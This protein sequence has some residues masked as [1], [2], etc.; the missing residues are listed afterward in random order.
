MDGCWAREGVVGSGH[1]WACD[2]TVERVGRLASA[3]GGIGE[4]CPG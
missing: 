4:M 3:K 2:T 1:G